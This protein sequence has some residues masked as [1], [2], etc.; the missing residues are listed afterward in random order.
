MDKY[1]NGK[2]LA[3][4]LL[5]SPFRFSQ[6]QD[7]RRR[8]ECKLGMWKVMPGNIGK[9]VWKGGKARKGA[10]KGFANNQ[11]P[12]KAAGLQ[13][14]WG[15]LRGSMEHTVE[16]SKLKGKEA[17]VLSTNTP[18]VIVLSARN[19]QRSLYRGMRLLQTLL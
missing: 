19:G 1:P 11:L 3:K 8:F 7:L 14:H 16:L 4:F 10:N 13:S 17:G 9:R 5:L 12:S 2:L 6:K 18:A 15:A